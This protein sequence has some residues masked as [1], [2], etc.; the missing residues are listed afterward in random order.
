MRR[1]IFLLISLLSCHLC[2][3][4][5]AIDQKLDSMQI[6]IGEQTKLTLS[7]VVNDGQRVK[8]PEF[9]RSQ[10]ITPGVEVLECRKP[11]TVEVDGGRLQVSRAYVLTSFDEKLYYIPSQ[12]IKVDNKVCA[13][14]G[15]ALKVLTVPVDTLHADKFYPPKDVQDNPFSWSEWRGPLAYSIISVFLLILALYIWRRMKSNKPIISRVKVVKYIPPHQKALNGIEKLKSDRASVSENQKEYYTKLTT[16]LRQYIAERFGFDAMEMTSS[17]IIVRL[18]HEDTEALNEITSLF[19]TAD[20]VKFAKH[21]ALINENDANLMS[22]LSFI[23]DTKSEEKPQ[24][25]VVTAEEKKEEQVRQRW[26]LKK[27]ILISLVVI[28]VALLI[29]TV[30]SVYVLI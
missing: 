30:Y 28:A 18:R 16:I 13:S 5:V 15:L 2:G 27:V 6:L 9:G 24:L 20:L 19:R 22:A 25:Q 12:K 1:I 26:I 10:Y 29:L 14:K 7:V 21:S 23:N 4:Q 11:D 8:F 3:A 17:E